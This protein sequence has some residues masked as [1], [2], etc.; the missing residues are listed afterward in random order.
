MMILPQQIIN[1]TILNLIEIIEKTSLHYNKTISLTHKSSTVP[2]NCLRLVIGQTIARRL[3]NWCVMVLE[4]MIQ[5]HIAGK[6]HRSTVSRPKISRE[7]KIG[8]YQPRRRKT[9]HQ[10]QVSLWF[11]LYHRISL[12]SMPFCWQDCVT[13]FDYQW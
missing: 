4:R 8:K 10:S 13:Q 5:D 1:N 9:H 3:P 12:L 11:L 2:P 7:F 6:F